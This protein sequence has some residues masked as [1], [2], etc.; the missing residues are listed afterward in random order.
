MNIYVGNLTE[1][2]NEGQIRQMFE[3][4][5]EVESVKIIKDRFSGRSKGFGFVEMPSNSEADKAIKALNGRLVNRKPIKVNPAD[6]GAKKKKKPLRKR[7][8]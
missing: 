5:G 6:S 2:V 4:F 1:Q 3:A 8:Y 7:R